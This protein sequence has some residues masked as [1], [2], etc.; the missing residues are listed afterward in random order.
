MGGKTPYGFRTEPH[1]IQGIKTKRLIVQSDEAEY[2]KQMYEMYADPKI[3]LHD[4]TRKLTVLGMRTY[5]G[6]PLSRATLSVILRNPIYV[7]ADLNIFEFYKNQGTDIFNSADDFI[8]TNGCYYYQGKGNKED[9]HKHL[10]GQQLVIAP[11]EGFIDPSLWLKVRKKLMASHTFQPA[12]KGRN[13]WLAGKIKCGRCGYALTTAHANGIKYF[14]CTV[15]A[16]SKDCKGC[17]CIKMHELHD[18]VYGEMVHELNAFKKLAEKKSAKNNPKLTKKQLEL[19]KI[20]SEIEKLIESLKT[21]GATLVSYVNATVEELDTQ[22]QLLMR[23]ISA[24]TFDAIP[25]TQLETISNYLDK[26]EDVSFED[27]QKVVDYLI[28]RVRATSDSVQIEW[29]I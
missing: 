28:T 20:E 18:V 25:S 4:I 26:W 11:H 27:K 5:H 3:S 10:Q 22:R 7:K 21:A 2:I 8:G 24:L 13:S 17:G 12:R 19:A 9:K 23:E 15:H 29:K 6:R 14:R 1:T 16:D